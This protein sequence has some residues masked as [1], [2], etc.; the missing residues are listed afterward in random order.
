MIRAEVT[1]R[2]LRAKNQLGTVALLQGAKEQA[3]HNMAID[4]KH[5]N[6]LKTRWFD[7]KKAFDP[8]NHDYLIK[9]VERL[10]RPTWIPKF[11]CGITAR[12]RIDIISGRNM[13]ISKEMGRGILLGESLS[14]SSSSCAWIL[15]VGG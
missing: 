6:V 15:W 4:R 2:G 7:L 3:M 10:D 5:G 11:L 13:T 9:C 12:W 1:K 14:R 8:I